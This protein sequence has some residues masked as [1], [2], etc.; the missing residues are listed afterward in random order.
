[1][2]RQPHDEHPFASVVER[3]W[4]LRRDQ[5]TNV[6]AVIHSTNVNT[7]TIQMTQDRS[8]QKPLVRPWRAPFIANCY[9]IA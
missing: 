7:T 1:M 6:G 3:L 8:E 5:T 2:R 4:V 9:G